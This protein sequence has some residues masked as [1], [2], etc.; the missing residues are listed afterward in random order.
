M[1]NKQGFTL[2]EM[3][4]V[5]LIIGIL[6]GIALPQYEMAVEK[7]K[8]TE[9]LMNMRTI[10]G[11]VERNILVS[12][13]DN[14]S[15][16]S[17]GNR[18]NWDIE[19]TGGIWIDNDSFQ[20]MTDYFKYLP[21]DDGSG[22]FVV[23]CNGKCQKTSNAWDNYLYELWGCYPSVDGDCPFSCYAESNKGKKICKAL[24]GLGVE[25]DS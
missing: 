3:L 22:L 9:A 6:A 8:A 13:T 19:L 14:G 25:N 24:E 7:A 10:I 12:G 4:V 21:T 2:I 17:Y 15:Y 1:K 11:A 18:N 5:V 16:E 23:R 20:Y